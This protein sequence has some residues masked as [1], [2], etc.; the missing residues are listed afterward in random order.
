M[1]DSHRPLL[2]SVAQPRV[3]ACVCTKVKV[4]GGKALLGTDKD[5]RIDA[6]GKHI[7]GFV[8][9]SPVSVHQLSS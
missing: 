4:R 7:E 3:C 1:R 8:H 2:F 6:G 5:E 9:S